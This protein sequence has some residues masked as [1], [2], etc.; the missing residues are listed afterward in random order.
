[1]KWKYRIIGGLVAF[2]IFGAAISHK[3]VW[4]MNGAVMLNPAALLDSTFSDYIVEGTGVVNGV[5]TRVIG[6]GIFPEGNAALVVFQRHLVTK[7]VRASVLPLEA[8]KVGP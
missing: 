8:T 2:A 3:L 6:F 5:N 4:H 7:E 1:M